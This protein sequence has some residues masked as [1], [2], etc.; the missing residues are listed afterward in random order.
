MPALHPAEANALD[1]RDKAFEGIAD[2]QSGTFEV[3]TVSSGKRYVRATL[4]LPTK[5]EP[6]PG[7]VASIVNAF[8]DAL[9]TPTSSASLL[10]SRAGTTLSCSLYGRRLGDFLSVVEPRPALSVLSS[11]SSSSPSSSP[12][13]AE[14]AAM[15]STT[16]STVTLHVAILPDTSVTTSAALLELLTTN[17]EIKSKLAASLA[18]ATSSSAAGSALTGP[19]GSPLF[20]EDGMDATCFNGVLDPAGESDVDCGGKSAMG[21]FP[22]CPPCAGGRK[23]TEDSQC[24][25]G[26]CVLEYPLRISGKCA[27]V[28]SAAPAAPAALNAAAAATFVATALA[29]LAALLL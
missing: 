5:S 16:F 10:P 12:S 18:S 1:R 29:A 4:S 21:I 19:V 26:Q 13:F 8:C 20:F 2:A 23:C 3:T 22:G 6:A 14:W 11:S 7:L 17:T 15:A 25:S 28:T 27:G 9:R 24:A